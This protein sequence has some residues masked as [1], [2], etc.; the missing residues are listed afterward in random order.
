MCILFCLKWINC[1]CCI[2]KKIDNKDI[3]HDIPF[4]YNIGKWRYS[5]AQQREQNRIIIAFYNFEFYNQIM[6]LHNSVMEIHK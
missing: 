4:N 5:M 6:G 3:I 2:E 1:D